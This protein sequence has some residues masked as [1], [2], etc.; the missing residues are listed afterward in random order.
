MLD[1]RCY[2][3]NAGHIVAVETRSPGRHVVPPGTNSL[4]PTYSESKSSPIH[5]CLARS[6]F[7]S[8]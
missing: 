6:I 2:F 1:Y 3:M 8:E 5:E 7:P 4:R